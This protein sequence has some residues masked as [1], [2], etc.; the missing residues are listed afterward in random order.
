MYSRLMSLQ[1]A[2]CLQHTTGFL[3]WTSFSAFIP[4]LSQERAEAEYA[5]LAAALHLPTP[6]YLRVP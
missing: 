6:L 5:V 1:T 3:V 4:G 2:G